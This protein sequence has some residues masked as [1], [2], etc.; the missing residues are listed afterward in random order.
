MRSRVQ[1]RTSVPVRDQLRSMLA[2][3][4]ARGRHSSG[5]KLPSERELAAAYGTSRTS[6]RQALE[7]LVEEG[8]L[9]R[10]MGKGTFVAS[11]WKPELT[12]GPTVE[13]LAGKRTR[14]LAFVIR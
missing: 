13:A 7:A 11:G 1:P 14:T 6:V 2:A 9:F 4:I 12:K 5:S 10:T 3:K 8:V